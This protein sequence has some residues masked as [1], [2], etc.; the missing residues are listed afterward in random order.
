MRPGTAL[1]L[2]PD[3]VGRPEYDYTRGLVLQLYHMADDDF[4]VINVPVGEGVAIAG[5]VKVHGNKGFYVDV[6]KGLEVV[7]YWQC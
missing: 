4:V 7:S 3:G 2:G 5:Q 6:N 1:L